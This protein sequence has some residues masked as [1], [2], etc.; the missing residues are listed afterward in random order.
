MCKLNWKKR[1]ACV[2]C[3]VF[4]LALLLAAFPAAVMAQPSIEVFKAAVDINGGALEPGDTITYTVTITNTGD[5][6]QA[7]NAGNE[8]ED[9]IPANALYVPASA[10][11]TSGTAAYELLNNR[12]TWNGPV[13]TGVLNS[14]VVSFSV[15]LGPVT[16]GTEISNQANV[17]WDSDG[18]GTNDA[19]EPSDNPGTLLITNDPTVLT[20]GESQTIT[21]LKTVTDTNGGELLAGDILQYNVVLGNAGAGALADNA[22]HEFQDYIPAHTTYVADS[23]SAGAGTI[24]YNSSSD[25]VVWD[26]VVP[27]LGVVNIS[28]QVTVDPYTPDNTIITN[29]GTHNFDSGGTNTNDASQLTDD[30]TVSGSADPT[31]IVITVLEV[32]ANKTVTDLNGGILLSEETLQY[33]I[34]LHD[35]E[36]FDLPDNA[37]IELTDSIPADTTY[38]EGSVS[39]TSGTVEYN[40][41]LNRIEW[42]GVITTGGQVTVSFQ[43]MVDAG[44][45]DDT[46]I[47]NQ[48]THSYDS[49]NNGTN[50]T[51]QLTDDPAL[52]GSA[53]PTDISANPTSTGKWYLAEGCTQG[54]FETWALVQN[55]GSTAVHVSLAFLTDQGEMSFPELQNVE[56]PARSR[57]TF[58]VQN[59]VQ[60]YDV[61]TVVE[62]SDG[63]VI[64]ERSVYWNDRQGGHDSIGVTGTAST[65]YLAEGC[66]LG[67]FETW[68]LV[69]NPGT[70]PVNVSLTLQTGEG[71]QVPLELQNAAI[72]ARGRRSFKLNDYVETYDVSTT[73]TTLTA[74]GEVVCERA[75]YWNDRKGGHDS[76]G[77]TSASADWYLAEGA[78]AG[79]FE[80]WVLV[81]NPGLTA[82]TVDLQLQTDLGLSAPT[83]LQGQEIPALGRRSFLINDYATSYDVSTHVQCSSGS[84]ICERAMYWNERNGGHNSIGVTGTAP[85]WYLAE[86]CT[87][88]GFQTWVLV[89]NPGSEAVT[90]NIRLQ[91]G[92]GE[93]SPDGLQNVSLAAQSRQ[94]FPIHFFVQSYEVST[95]VEC[96]D[97]EVI[98]ERAVYWDTMVEGTDSVGVPGPL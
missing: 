80:T 33:D 54:G 88:G 21:A 39:A 51:T 58:P 43:V 55:P 82:A 70:D 23:A 18:N 27:S 63:Q 9:A 41:T 28:F 62:C 57:K 35:G 38:V 17:N 3:T 78:T 53:D 68:V 85:A 69:E 12:I 87:Q 66:T 73:V 22:G 46:V 1:L 91:T 15:I 32:T 72:P 97:G 36:T 16:D 45:A 67:G 44:T 47:S 50:D 42:N 19:V 10:T 59:Y 61:S 60:A 14:V 7:D 13:N 98:A 71:L 30:P 83:G 5:V 79:G 34:V 11:A 8:L 2:A 64:C 86:G 89:Q 92:E 24:A 95:Y 37:G 56:V 49:D 76:V 6:A 48:G 25:D 81:Q 40:G 94:S 20:V 84:V 65:W 90:I 4:I 52:P 77:V 29:Q 93:I 26:G 74:G 31:N 96:T 75:M